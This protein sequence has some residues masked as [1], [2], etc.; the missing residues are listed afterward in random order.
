M[1]TNWPAHDALGTTWQPRPI[2]FFRNQNG[3][4]GLIGE[5][6]CELQR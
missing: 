1:G 5:M 2:A 3:S 6:K 4:F